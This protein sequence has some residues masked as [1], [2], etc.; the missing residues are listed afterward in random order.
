MAVID[1]PLFDVVFYDINRSIYMKKFILLKFLR[2]IDNIKTV[3]MK[4]NKEKKQDQL[5]IYIYIY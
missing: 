3:E 5:S 2:K 1:F 4:N